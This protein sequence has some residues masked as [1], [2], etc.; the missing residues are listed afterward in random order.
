[1]FLSDLLSDEHCRNGSM[2]DNACYTYSRS[3]GSM[4]VDVL[5]PGLLG[6]FE[7]MIGCDT[8]I[9]SGQRVVSAMCEDCE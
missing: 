2:M 5:N 4:T 1:M 9:V 3:N 8:E 7:P 6:V